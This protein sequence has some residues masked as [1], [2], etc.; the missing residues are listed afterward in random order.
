[1]GMDTITGM[2][3]TT[4]TSTPDAHS[5]AAL[6]TLAQWLSPAFPVG[7]FAY[8]HGLEWTIAT[9]AVHDGDSLQAWLADVIRFG[10]GR[11]D[12]ILLARAMD[13]GADVEALGEWTLALAASAERERETLEQGAAFGATVAT[14]TGEAMPPLP[15]PVALGVA[16]R[17]LGLPARVVAGFYLQSFAGNLVSA[18]VRMVPL[19]QTEGQRVLAALRPVIGT[20]AAEAMAAPMEAIGSAAIGADLAAMRHETM[21]TRMFRT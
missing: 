3:Q 2:K 13:D 4:T 1:M 9:G 8:S 14:L 16:A 6:L 21:D 18:A 5:E 19:G 11:S 17:R 12:A 20:V 15:Y 10:T 7:A